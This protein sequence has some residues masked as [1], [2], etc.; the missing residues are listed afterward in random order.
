MR[1]IKLEQIGGKVKATIEGENRSIPFTDMAS[2]I[3]HC[4]SHGFT[5]TNANTLPPFFQQLI[6]Q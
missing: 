6:K 1:N 3:M 2:A 5:I 4:N